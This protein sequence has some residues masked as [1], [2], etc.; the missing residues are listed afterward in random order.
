MLPIRICFQTKKQKGPGRSWTLMSTGIFPILG[1]IHSCAHAH[2]QAE[3]GE[4]S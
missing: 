2:L 3:L 1:M 4:L